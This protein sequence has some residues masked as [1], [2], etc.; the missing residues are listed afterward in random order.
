MATCAYCKQEMLEAYGC[1]IFFLREADGTFTTRELYDGSLGDTCSDCGCH[2]GGL[3]HLGCDIER[4]TVC[5]MQA[6]GCEGHSDYDS[7][8]LDSEG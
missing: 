7:P 1:T 3:H 6:I 5:G 2:Y 8:S 4:C